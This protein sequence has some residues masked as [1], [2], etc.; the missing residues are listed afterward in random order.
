MKP[1]RDG[2]NYEAVENFPAEMT[3][4]EPDDAQK[5]ALK[6][7]RLQAFGATLAKQRDEWITARRA[8]GW[9][10]RVAEDLD[11]YHAID[12]SAAVPTMM[13]SAEQGYPIVRDRSAPTRSSVFIGL[14]RQKTNA[15]EARCV[16][17]V[18]PTDERNFSLQATPIPHMLRLS[19]DQSQAVD[20]ETGAPITLDAIDPT[21]GAAVPTPVKRSDIAQA[22]AAVAGEKVKAMERLIDDQLVECDYRGELRKVW[23]DAA[24]MGVGVLKGPVI[25]N[26]TAKAW[27]KV[28]GGV[29]AL[30]VEEKTE[31]ASFR[32]D[33]RF[34]WEDPDCGEDVQKGKGIYELEQM[35]RKSVRALAK[36]PGYIAEQIAAV[37]EEGPARSQALTELTNHLGRNLFQKNTYDVWTY[38]GELEPEDL[39]AA[40]LD[41]ETDGPETVLRCVSG[42]VVMINNTVVKAYLNP[43]E[44]GDLPYDFMPLE[45]VVDSPR[46]LGVPHLMRAPQR[47]INAAWRMMLDNA[48]VCAGPQVIVKKGMIHPEDGTL[49]LYARKFW[50]YTGPE[51]GNPAEAFTTVEISMHQAE[52]QNIINM[53]VQLADAE[54]STPMYAQGDGQGAGAAETV[55]GMT[56]LMNAS[57]VVLRRMVKQFDDYVTK[58]HITRYYDYNMA[59]AEDEA[60]K[61]DMQI[62][63]RGSS[64]LLVRD[65]QNQAFTSLLAAASN[66]VF[67]PE[68]NARKLFE[69]ALQA[70]H[71]QPGDILKSDTEKKEEA[72]RLA[73]AGPQATDPRVE[74]ATIR[75]QASV[76]EAQA[77]AAGTE[78]EIALREKIAEQ[79]HAAII[80]KLELEREIALL[81]YAT[82]KQS[83]IEQAK[84]ELAIAAMGYRQKSEQLHT[85][86]S[87]RINTGAGV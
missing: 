34:V 45:K 84:K 61:G 42:C 59:Y 74:A 30:T 17:I 38:T 70:Q 2:R 60:V 73:A 86:A 82:E 43:L 8:S 81:K 9:D 23:H 56:M 58:P 39:E 67:A 20:P 46:G 28:E 16:D 5:R 19:E 14:T 33:P 87:L 55:G 78:N 25:T 32:I 24:V 66:P 13:D 27:R 51:G 31:P 10:K 69:K 50:E 4:A 29:Y 21:T 35:T 37:L 48:A 79:N 40:G 49:S 12:R 15:L 57:N 83:T 18:L 44:T 53:G 3:G 76:Q 75:A 77:R 41:F 11:Q 64:A 22:A 52:L 47:V 1:L 71:V 7:D 68:I 80:A 62:D 63:A 26:R 36:H 85:E 72:D 65:I 6:L 54:T